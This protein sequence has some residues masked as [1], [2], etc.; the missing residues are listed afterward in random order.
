MLRLMP[1]TI[2]AWNRAHLRRVGRLILV[3]SAVL[4]MLPSAEA[5]AK[6]NPTED[7]QERV[8]IFA[9]ERIG[10][11]WIESHFNS[12]PEG[13]PT[14]NQCEISLGEVFDENG[15]ESP[16]LSY[17]SDQ[18]AGAKKFR[19]VFRRYKDMSTMANDVA[20]RASDIVDSSADT[21]VL[22]T[23]G[24]GSKRKWKLGR[25][26]KSCA[27]VHCKAISTDSKRRLATHS[28]E[29]CAKGAEWI[30]TSVE[31]IKAV[32]REAGSG[33]VEKLVPVG[34]GGT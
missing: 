16:N 2:K 26:K 17:S 3:P 10:R 33:L 14:L 34:G 27:E 23:V 8:V 25:K 24:V 11:D 29:R 19:T 15:F 18:K 31:A 4:L 22:C 28:I 20:V 30:P 7:V 13:R 6:V 21:V 5:R 9:S 12:I 32:C 1:A